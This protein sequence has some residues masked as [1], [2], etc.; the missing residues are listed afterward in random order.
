M[1]L[2]FR[3]AKLE[4]SR[5]LWEWRNDP[6][7]RQS[8]RNQDIVPWESHQKWFAQSLLST[9]RRIYLCQK[10][11]QAVGMVRFDKLPGEA[12]EISVNIAP[13]MRGRGI[14][15]EVIRQGTHF[16]VGSQLNAEE[17]EIRAVVNEQNP[18]SQ[19]A[20][21]KAG[22][23]IKDQALEGWITLVCARTD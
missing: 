23:Q 7:T 19:K 18:A 10:G 16:F 8:S 9:T 3:C 4:D 11:S 5:L 20:F 14:G 12:Y 15:A 22:F 17:A 21:K 1:D 13:E 6:V 2:V